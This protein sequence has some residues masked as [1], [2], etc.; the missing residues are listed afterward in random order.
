M[1]VQRVASQTARTATV[2]LVMRK[3]QQQIAGGLN[4]S[5]TEVVCLQM[6]RRTACR[7]RGAPQAEALGGMKV[8]SQLLA[9]G[10]IV[11]IVGGPQA[12][13]GCDERSC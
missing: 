9:A 2:R 1:A 10:H 7:R 12:S 11:I 5:T 6:N 3:R 8:A 4:P 13:F